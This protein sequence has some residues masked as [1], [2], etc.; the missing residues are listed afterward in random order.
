M[1]IEPLDDGRFRVTVTYRDDGAEELFLIGGLAGVDPSDRRLRRGDDGWWTRTYEVEGPALLT[2]YFT[3]RLVPEGLA[4]LW[5]DPLNPARHV[6]EADPDVPD[7][8][9]L[10]VSVVELP[11]YPPRRWSVERDVPRGTVERHRLASE[12]LGNERSVFTYAPPGYDDAVAYPLIV[13]FDGQ[14]YTSESYVPLPTVLDNL[15]AE[16]AIPPVVAVLPASLDNETRSRELNRHEPFVEFLVEELL[17]WTR[18][19]LSFD[20]SRVLTAGSSL[21][22]LTAAFCALKRPDV[23]GLVLSQSGAFQRGLATD[24]AAA[25]RLP[26]RFALD[27][28]VYETMTFE[29]M[30]SLYHANLHMRDVLVAKGYDVSFVEYPGGHDYLCWRETIADG[31]IALLA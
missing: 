3:P 9:E 26:V 30:P 7:D 27:V 21:G 28:G 15:I 4:D 22:G 31:L 14:A 1:E 10:V 8:G 11:G 5:P 12:R 19:R 29:R 6:Y 13:C 18:E 17:P 25:E 20:A 2:Y 16:G 23:F 24:F